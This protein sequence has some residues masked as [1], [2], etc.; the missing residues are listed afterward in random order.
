MLQAQDRSTPDLREEPAFVSYR[1]KDV[2]PLSG[3]TKW[4]TIYHPNPSMAQLHNVLR[5]EVR[6]LKINLP[7]A[8]GAVPG[9]SV[10]DHVRPHVG[11][12]YVVH[13]DLKNAYG[14]VCPQLLREM[15]AAFG[16]SGEWI[17][18]TAIRY[19]MLPG[20]GL[21]TGGG[22]CPDL[23][24]VY[25]GQLID[26]PLDALLQAWGDITYTRYLDDLVFSSS[27]P[28]GRRRRHQILEV[29]RAAGF[30][31]S[32]QK[33]QVVDLA[34]DPHVVV[35]GVGLRLTGETF[36]SRR[37]R[38]QLFEL[39]SQAR[40]GELPIHRLAGWMGAFY[41]VVGKN[42][43]HSPSERRLHEM[44]QQLKG[45][46]RTRT[47]Y[48]SKRIARR[49]AYMKRMHPLKKQILR[50]RYRLRHPQVRWR[51]R[52]RMRPVTDVS[53]RDEQAEVRPRHGSWMTQPRPRPE[54]RKHRRAPHRRKYLYIGE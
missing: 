44:Y 8:K 14:S 28:I 29:I 51:S 16:R 36:L 50:R 25:A 17:G 38:R 11:Q 42:G 13:Y 37:F 18:N 22:A 32:A 39:L 49:R 27:R 53:T 2:N 24:N 1:K 6:S 34:R 35:N 26:A 20:A 10:M 47:G 3:A 43:G 19:A 12:Q 4:R 21:A 7:Y 40:A 41:G 5:K 33:T 45:W 23:F 46:L 48:A 54:L 31:L 9:N 30:E 15:F 52:S